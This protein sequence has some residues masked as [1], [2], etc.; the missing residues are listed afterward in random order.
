MWLRFYQAVGAYK[1]IP[2]GGA[3]TIFRFP[4][5]SQL[6]NGTSAPLK[7]PIIEHQSEPKRGN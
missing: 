4:C 3:A 1:Y 5:P 2:A 6:I 7:Y